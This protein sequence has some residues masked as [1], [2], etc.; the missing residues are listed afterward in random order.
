MSKEKLKKF[1]T[2]V[3]YEAC[4]VILALFLLHAMHHLYEFVFAPL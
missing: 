2:R 4:G 1:F 3:F